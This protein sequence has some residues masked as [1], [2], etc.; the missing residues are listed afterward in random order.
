MSVLF[1]Q[2]DVKE[3]EKNYKGW[4]SYIYSVRQPNGTIKIRRFKSTGFTSW[5]CE[6]T[7]A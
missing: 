5:N 1:N 7:I 3:A 6:I 4:L 2:K